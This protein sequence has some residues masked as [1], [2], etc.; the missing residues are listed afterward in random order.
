[1]STRRENQPGDDGPRPRSLKTPGRNRRVVVGLWYLAVYLA[2][3]YAAVRW[4][5]RHGT[6]RFPGSD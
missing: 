5:H 3:V 1:M 6:T 4:G 2:L